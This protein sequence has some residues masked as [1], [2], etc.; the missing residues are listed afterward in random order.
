R[1]TPAARD[2]RTRMPRHLPLLL[3]LAAAGCGGVRSAQVPARDEIDRLPHVETI[4]P[5]VIPSLAV[6]FEVTALVEAMEKADLCARVP[7]VVESLQPDAKRPETDIG[8]RITAGEPL[9]KI[10]VPDLDAEKAFKEAL[11]EQ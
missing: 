7:G 8:R 9:I 5:E 10:A 11:V 6:R 2:G 3:L 4:Q 1:L